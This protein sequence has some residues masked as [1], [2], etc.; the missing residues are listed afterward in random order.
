MKYVSFPLIL[1]LIFATSCGHGYKFWDISKFK[2][3]DTALRDQEEIKL[4]YTSRGPDNNEDRDYYIHVVAVSQKTG[5]T[6]N[7]L[8]FIENGFK[9]EDQDKIYNFFDENN[10]ATK[11]ILDNSDEVKDISNIDALTKTPS[12]KAFKVARDP[13]FDHIADNNYS[14]VVGSIGTVK[15]SN[16]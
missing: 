16:N 8:T 11:L 13:K 1:L 4:L 3:V 12:K 9:Q 15:T 10:I 14:T 6:V 7:I 5:D 2:I